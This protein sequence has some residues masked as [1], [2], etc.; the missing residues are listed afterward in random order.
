MEKEK[1]E[2]TQKEKKTEQKEVIFDTIYHWTV[3]LKPYLIIL[4]YP[5]LQSL[6]DSNRI[7]KSY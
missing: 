7:N 6:R 2:K 5:C 1:N 3:R 4:I